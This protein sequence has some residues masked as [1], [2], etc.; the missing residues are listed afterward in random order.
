MSKESKR[1]SLKLRDI[2]L[3][4]HLSKQKLIRIY[5][6]TYQLES[7]KSFNPED[8]K[9]ILQQ[10]IDSEL[11]EVEYN[12]KVIPDLCT[13]LAENIRTI[14][15]EQAY[16]R[17]RIIVS[18]SIGQKRQQSVHVFHSFLWDHQRDGFVAHNFENCHIFAN[19]VVYGIYL[20]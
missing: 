12:E 10:H 18:V 14:I 6:P 13:S 11:Q 1:T 17:Y 9:K 19:I 7:R 8:V 15:K 16:D 2:I 20:D 5:Q 4:R 3:G